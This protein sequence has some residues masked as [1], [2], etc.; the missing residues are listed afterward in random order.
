METLRLKA[1]PPVEDEIENWDDDDFLI[2]G[3]DL[4]INS[5]STS[6]NAPSHRRDSQSSFR[7]DF[8]SIH[9]E[10]EK[11]VVLPGDDEKSTLDAI[12]AAARAG[13]P[14]PKNV[15]PSALMGGTIKR[16][17][18]TLSGK[19]Q[20]GVSPFRPRSTILRLKLR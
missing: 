6:V 17:G 19:V 18:L 9:G 5:H 7:S 11:Q 12:A 15:P 2:D 10:E 8:E 16:L 3:D 14:I 20:F 4:T 1:R 13:I